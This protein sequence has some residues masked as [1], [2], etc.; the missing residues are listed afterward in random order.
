MALW[1]SKRGHDVGHACTGESAVLIK[2]ELP[3]ISLQLDLDSGVALQ[4]FPDFRERPFLLAE[5]KVFEGKWPDNHHTPAT[6]KAM[7][8]AMTAIGAGSPRDHSLYLISLS[9]PSHNSL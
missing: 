4:P 3:C 5:G 7:A 8:S 6:A 1:N 2:P 9:R